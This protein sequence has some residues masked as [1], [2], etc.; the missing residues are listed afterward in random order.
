MSSK[1]DATQLAAVLELLV[2]VGFELQHAVAGTIAQTI[3]F[4][5]YGVFFAIA[6]YSIFRKGLRSWASIIMLLVVVY[7]YLASAAQWAMNAWV[8]FAKIHGFLMVTSVPFPEGAKLAAVEIFKVIGVQEAIF[9]FNMAVGDSVVVWRTWAVYQDRNRR[10]IL[11]ILVPGIL[12]LLTFVFS[13]IDTVCNN[14]HGTA[15]LPAICNTAGGIAWG[16]SAA[17]NIACTIL[18]GLKARRHRKITRPLGKPSRM[19]AETILSILFDSG[20]IYSLL[21]LSQV[22]SFFAAANL[23]TLTSPSV[24]VWGSH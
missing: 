18:I 14:Y 23:I 1:S 12:L 5:A 24:F 17:T 7:L 20:F 11:A 3:F 19:S 8:T 4:S 6:V 9:D 13:I 21:W 15:P 16:L 22:I 2:E 10:R